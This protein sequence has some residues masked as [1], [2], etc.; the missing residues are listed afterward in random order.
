MSVSAVDVV[1]GGGGEG[2]VGLRLD[3]KAAFDGIEVSEEDIEPVNDAVLLIERG[4]WKLDRR[5]TNRG[6]VSHIGCLSG[7]LSE[8][9]TVHIGSKD[10]QS[11][12]C[13]KHI[14]TAKPEK[15]LLEAYVWNLTSKQC[16]TTNEFATLAFIQ[17][18]IIRL[19]TISLLLCGCEVH[20]L[21]ISKVEPSILNV[22][23]PQVW[24]HVRAVVMLGR[25]LATQLHLPHILNASPDPARRGFEGWGHLNLRRRHGSC[26]LVSGVLRHEASADGELKDRLA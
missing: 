24:D 6:E 11:E 10:D 1:N 25:A 8:S 13:N 18:D 4:E 20:V 21:D 15:R 12:L 7:S 16:G 2:R 3:D 5:E 19:K 23:N 26:R 14:M 17:Q 9:S 22:R